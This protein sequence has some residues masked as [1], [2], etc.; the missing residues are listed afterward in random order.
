MRLGE[1][2]QG[3]DCR[4]DDPDADPNPCNDA[5]VGGVVVEQDDSSILEGWQQQPAMAAHV[6]PK[7]W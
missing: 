1:G 2:G 7:V 3:Q 6:L 4:D 5:A